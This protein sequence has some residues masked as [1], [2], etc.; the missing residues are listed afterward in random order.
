LSRSS[1]ARARARRARSKHRSIAIDR[2]IV[3]SFV[4][5]FV[6]ECDDARA[7]LDDD[8]SRVDH[9]RASEVIDDDDDGWMNE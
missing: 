7:S 6:R 1:P 3:R 4:R 9:W 5:S 8:R 2:S